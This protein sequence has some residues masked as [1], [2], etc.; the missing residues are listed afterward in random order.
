MRRKRSSGRTWRVCS[1]FNPGLTIELLGRA[2]SALRGRKA[3]SL[4]RRTGPAFDFLTA[5]DTNGGTEGF[6]TARH[7]TKEPRPYKPAAP[8]SRESTKQCWCRL[9][10]WHT[11][12]LVPCAL[13]SPH[14]WNRTSGGRPG[15]SPEYCPLPPNLTSLVKP[16][17]Q[18][19]ILGFKSK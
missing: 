8:R 10:S 7:G 1:V 15:G 16:M 19:R 2:R 5:V 6:A 12:R 18:V 4:L 9:W 14:P 3:L 13:L 11:G 17:K